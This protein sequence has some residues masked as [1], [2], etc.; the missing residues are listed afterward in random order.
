MN[1]TAN[2]FR[3]PSEEEWEYAALAEQTSASI[4][5]WSGTSKPNKLSEY[6]W[7]DKNSSNSSHPVGTKLPN[8]F[9]LFDMSG[10]VDEWIWDKDQL[11][12]GQW[13]QVSKGGAWSDSRESCNG[14]THC[15]YKDEDNL[16]K[17]NTL[18]FRLVRNKE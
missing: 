7:F 17:G 16:Y 10:N 3:L 11:E 12:N 6:M 14:L 15:L 13:C 4:Y 2:G 8:D 9:G 1:I 18:G 5:R